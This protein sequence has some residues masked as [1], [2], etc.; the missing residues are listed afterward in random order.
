MKGLG[1]P[2]YREGLVWFL[3]KTFCYV[4]LI[5]RLNNGTFRKSIH[6]FVRTIHK[7]WTSDI[8]NKIVFMFF[9][10]RNFYTDT[11][12]VKNKQNLI[13]FVHLKMFVGYFTFNIIIYMFKNYFELDV[14]S[15]VDSKLY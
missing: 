14:G 4:T 8:Y 12:Y 2:I 1:W 11:I 6:I 9:S 7:I 13:S 15:Y 10:L 5:R 3:Y